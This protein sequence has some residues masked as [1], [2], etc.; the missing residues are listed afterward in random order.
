MDTNTNRESEARRE[1]FRKAVD[2]FLVRRVVGGARR[3]SLAQALRERAIELVDYGVADTYLA[4]TR[5]PFVSE[6][7]ARHCGP[8]WRDL[9]E[10]E[11]RERFPDR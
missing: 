3:R 10:E 2:E 1:E 9:T 11:R 4:G 7:L 5:E 8:L 6:F